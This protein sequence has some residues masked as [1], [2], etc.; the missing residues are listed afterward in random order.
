ME[1]AYLKGLK[2]GAEIQGEV[3][4]Q[5]P[6]PAPSISAQAQEQAALERLQYAQQGA[7]RIPWGWA[8]AG[9]VIGGATWVVFQRE[10]KV[11]A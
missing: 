5:I 10:G 9:A 8:L 6:Y 2:R 3:E 7:L 1:E 4:Y 11:F